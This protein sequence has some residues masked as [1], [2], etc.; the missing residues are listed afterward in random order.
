MKKTLY[1]AI[2]FLAVMAMA[3]QNTNNGGKE[4]APKT[5]ELI[6][7]RVEQM[8]QMHEVFDADK[9]LTADM[10]ALQEKAES[11]HFWANFCPGFQ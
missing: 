6:K 8:I 4:Q 2:A 5:E 11:V 7:Q 9:I 10:L 1:A 3:C